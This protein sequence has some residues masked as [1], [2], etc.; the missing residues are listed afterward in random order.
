M[1]F[2]RILNVFGTI[3]ILLVT[4]IYGISRPALAQPVTVSAS[5]LDGSM[6]NTTNS[7]SP[8]PTGIE[9]GEPSPIANE[10]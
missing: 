7:S 8:T 5:T 4:N 2:F 6:S 10:H 9:V 3:L 1:N